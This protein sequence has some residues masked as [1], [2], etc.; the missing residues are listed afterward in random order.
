MMTWSDVVLA[1]L[2]Y[3]CLRAKLVKGVE[4][5]PQPHKF[6]RMTQE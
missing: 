2:F 3:I 1:Y 5:M 6:I 4:I